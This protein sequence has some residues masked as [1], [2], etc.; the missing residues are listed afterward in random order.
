M[1]WNGWEEVLDPEVF[2]LSVLETFSC[3]K[4]PQNIKL[5]SF[6]QLDLLEGRDPSSFS[7]TKEGG[8]LSVFTVYIQ[9]NS[10][11]QN[12]ALPTLFQYLLCKFRGE[13]VSSGHLV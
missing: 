7:D 9:I 8:R 11:L 10:Q 4:R 3:F 13:K 5:T 1:L 6:E 12:S 2:I